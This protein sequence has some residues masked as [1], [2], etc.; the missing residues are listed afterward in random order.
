MRQLGRPLGR[1]FRSC[2]AGR[3][4]DTTSS[5]RFE[6]IVR[7]DLYRQMLFCQFFALNIFI[8]DGDATFIRPNTAGVARSTGTEQR[9]FPANVAIRRMAWKWQ[10]SISAVKIRY[11]L[12]EEYLNSFKEFRFPF[13]IH[14]NQHVG[15]RL[16]EVSLSVS[17]RQNSKT[18]SGLSA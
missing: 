17:K 15:F 2:F 18:F 14:P 5:S 6:P 8:G 1:N 3:P 4:T 12:L 10:C 11:Q 9:S 7:A 16:V 13:A